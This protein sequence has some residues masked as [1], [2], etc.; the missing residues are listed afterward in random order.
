MS[1]NQI[2]LA[3]AIAVWKSALERT[4]KLFQS[5]SSEELMKEVAPRRNR[6]AYLWGHLTAMHDRM[7]VLLGVGERV[8]P[9]FDAIFLTAADKANELPPLERIQQ[10][11]TL[12][13][14]RLN[15]GIAKLTAEQWLEPHTAVSAEDFAKD[16][17]R[18]KFSILLTRTSH[19]TYHLGQANLLDR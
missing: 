15:D 7:I 4:D 11:W 12:V 17:L 5:L 8:D 16:A 2:F 19:L 10:A 9:S 14:Q 13:S 6:L 3:N 18:N 1:Q